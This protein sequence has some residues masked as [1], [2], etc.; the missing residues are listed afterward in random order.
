VQLLEEMWAFEV[1]DGALMYL[2]ERLC[3]SKGFDMLFETA[4]NI[5]LLA[6]TNLL[7][8]HRFCPNTKR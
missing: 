3:L 2:V 6:F 1:E 4:K 8:L 7:K 5:A